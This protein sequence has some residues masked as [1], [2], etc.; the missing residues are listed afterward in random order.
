M[1]FTI[2]TI[3]ENIFTNEPAK[4][5]LR[6]YLDVANN[7]NWELMHSYVDE[8]G[9]WPHTNV[10]K[11]ALLDT[12]SHANG[13]PVYRAGNVCFFRNTGFADTTVQWED[14][15]ILNES[16]YCSEDSSVCLSND[17]CCSGYCRFDNGP[18]NAGIC[19]VAPT[20][21]PTA[22]TGS[23]TALTDPPTAPTNPPT[24]TTEPPTATTNPPTSAPT[25]CE[26]IE[27]TCDG[28]PANVPGCC[29]TGIKACGKGR[30]KVNH[31]VCTGVNANPGDPTCQ[32]IEP[33]CDFPVDTTSNCC[34]VPQLKSC[35][36][37][38]NK[39]NIYV[40]TGLLG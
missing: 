24:A 35:G 13:D 25:T 31:T 18:E 14:G 38:R 12:C 36:K 2:T 4:V 19:S 29:A 28:T 37:G 27:P 40:C 15:Y 6:L 20:D 11:A 21:P 8:P 32:A 16:T 39:T 17:E 26:A 34:G 9:A 3:P 23:P 10:E 33:T 7:G 1:K 22:P 5:E 30:N